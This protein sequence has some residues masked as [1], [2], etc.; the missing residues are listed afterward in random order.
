M[1]FRG[2]FTDFGRLPDQLAIPF[3]L[4]AS[5]PRTCNRQ[6]LHGQEAIPSRRNLQYPRHR[7]MPH[8]Q[9]RNFK[10]LARRGLRARVFLSPPAT[11]CAVGVLYSSKT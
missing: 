11:V 7:T 4:R 5:Q 6:G 8:P 9:Q 3:A 2:L 10:T 1:A